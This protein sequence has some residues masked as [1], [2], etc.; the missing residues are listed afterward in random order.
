V[1]SNK[2]II[3]QIEFISEY[4]LHVL[5]DYL[6]NIED[7]YYKYILLEKIVHLVMNDFTSYRIEKKT[8]YL[9]FF[10][11]K[12]LSLELKQVADTIYRINKDNVNKEKVIPKN[13]KDNIKELVK[14]FQKNIH[15]IISYLSDD[16]YV[17][18]I[19]EESEENIQLKKLSINSPVNLSFEGID[20]IICQ[21]FYG[22]QIEMR[23]QEMH[24][25]SMLKD[26]LIIGELIVSLEEKIK[27]KNISQGTKNY[28]N[29]LLNYVKT[30]QK[31][32]IDDKLFKSV[33]LLV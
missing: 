4:P 10:E 14:V 21:M 17:M 12:S 25:L 8:K 27:S 13:K 23:N 2:K 24:D 11:N 26:S 33:N 28:L 29:E 7:L 22:K 6:H 31:K 3:V 5:L 9:S 20:K 18:I 1:E 32:L 30:K 15:P 16:E 19:D